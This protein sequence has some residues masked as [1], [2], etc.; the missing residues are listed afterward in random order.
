MMLQIYIYI[1]FCSLYSIVAHFS[2]NSVHS[3]PTFERVV[4]TCRRT[5]LINIRMTGMVGLLN[6]YDVF[7]FNLE[8]KNEEK[9][10]L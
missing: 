10:R 5:S 8:Q 3:R 2:V 4:S 9:H 1:Y 6:P 7:R